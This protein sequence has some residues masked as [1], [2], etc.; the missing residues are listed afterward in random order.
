[1]KK[2][3]VAMISLLI[4]GM[5]SSAQDRLEFLGV[6]VSGTVSSLTQDLKPAGFKADRYRTGLFYGKFHK[7]PVDLV[8]GLDAEGSDK[9][10]VLVLSYSVAKSWKATLNQYESV[11]MALTMDYGQPTMSR[12]EYDYPYTEADGFRA[13]DEGK[14]RFITTYS[15]YEG[16]TTDNGAPVGSAAAFRKDGGKPFLGEITLTI[17]PE[18]H[19]VRIYFRAVD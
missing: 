2:I 15:I 16:G 6:P 10:H 4:A 19:K 18:D 9:V 3:L 14:C 1:M 8:L 11:K 13:M 12:E 5:V 17:S 7:Q